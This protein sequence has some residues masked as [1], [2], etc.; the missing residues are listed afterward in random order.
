M[1]L[2]DCANPL[3][4]FHFPKMD[5]FQNNVIRVASDKRDFVLEGKGTEN[6]GSE[7]GDI[8]M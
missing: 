6:R 2:L 8:L 7:T 1:F 4:F 3:P 5:N